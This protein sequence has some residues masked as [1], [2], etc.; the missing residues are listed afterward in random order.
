MRRKAFVSFLVMVLFGYFSLSALSA[1]HPHFSKTVIVKIGEVEA[2]VSFFTAPANEEHVKNAKVGAF[3]AG[4]GTLTL[5]GDLTAGDLTLKA[6]DYTIGAIKNG[7]ADWTMAL[8]QGKLGFNDAPDMAKVI[9]L[10]SV[11][12][13]D[14]ANA[15]HIY[16][17]IMPGHGK[18]EGKTVLIW[19]FGTHHLSGVIS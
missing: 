17:D 12:S 18:T 7:D 19:H 5:S 11:Y 1:P 2:K 8:H 4:F 9:K 14:H 13:K 16:F 10:Q 3:S 15:A 6:G